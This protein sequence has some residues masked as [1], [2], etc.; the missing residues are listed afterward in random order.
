MSTATRPPKLVGSAI[1][2]F[3]AAGLVAVLALGGLVLFAIARVSHREALRSAVDR[4]Y[5]A[6]YGIVEPALDTALL[7]EVDTERHN[8]EI[9][10]LDTLFQTRVLS[11]RVVRVK[12]WTP[13]GRVAYSDEPALIGEQFPRKTDHIDALN[14]GIASAEIADLSSPENRFDRGS[15][16]LLEV[17]LP[18]RLSDGR[19]LIYEQYERYDSVTGNRNRL[20]AQ[21]ALPLGL[22][23]AVL[24]LTQLPLARS[25]SR[26]V[27]R[28]EGERTTLL[29]LAMTASERERERI[30]A[31]LHDGVVQDLSGLTFELAATARATHDPV[32]RL[33]LERCE[34]VARHAMRQLRS[35]LVDLHPLNVHAVG[36]VAALDALALPLRADGVD[37]K[38]DVDVAGLSAGAESLLYRSAQ[39][40][41][42]NVHEHSG[43]TA[44][45]VTAAVEGPTVRLV[46]KDNGRGFTENTRAKQLED[47]HLGLELQRAVVQRAGGRMSV[48]S[49]LGQGTRVLVEIPA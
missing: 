39:E 23:L 4:A 49:S 43:A 38:V 42:R 29:E 34:A 9:A 26:R 16:P 15:G 31:D 3:G 2:R 22:G 46:V 35:S 33:E 13:G 11:E 8:A 24:W 1:F 28:A 17:Y 10:R 32:L 14:T 37:V 27:R 19:Q 45:G 44:V 20:L 7:D 40:L 21:L 25:L 18:V 5:L 47:G 41:L 6:G 48:E 36:L 12:L 30:A